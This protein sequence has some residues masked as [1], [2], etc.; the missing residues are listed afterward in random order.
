MDMINN[1][2]QGT[3][4]ECNFI[5]YTVFLYVYIT[6]LSRHTIFLHFVEMILHVIIS[7]TQFERNFYGTYTHFVSLI[8]HRLIAISENHE[9]NHYYCALKIWT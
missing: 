1:Y 5:W 8:I 2:I 6:K 9:I 3:Q 7:G 4:S